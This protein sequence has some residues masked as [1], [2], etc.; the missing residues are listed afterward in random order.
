MLYNK[1]II[2]LVLASL[3]IL[4]Q[5]ETEIKKE[6]EIFDIKKQNFEKLNEKFSKNFFT[7][8]MI[9][10]MKN[11]SIDNEK[12]RIYTKIIFYLR[13]II[14]STDNIVDNENKGI[15]FLKNDEIGNL[16]LKNTFLNL[17]FQDLLTKEC[18][19]LRNID[20]NISSLLLKKIYIIA[21]SE[22]LRE[23]NIYKKYP[24]YEYIFNTIHSR[25]GGELLKLGLEVPLKIEKNYTLKMYVDGIYKIGLALQAFDD[26]VDLDEDNQNNKINLYQ[27]MLYENI[28]F[29]INKNEIAE[30]YLKNAINMSY[31][32][33]KILK[34]NNYPLNSLE[35]KKLLKKLFELRGLEKFIYLIN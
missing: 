23:L 18:L 12:I 6:V 13:Q 2:R 24:S 3:K 26:F 16:S 8:L 33:F 29:P 20:E 11:S 32:G 25:I 22:D 10:F 17:V 31:D 34:E 1:E 19:K 15:F 4:K 7:I 28:D 35:E 27:A 14:T 30:R 5:I 21:K 9:T